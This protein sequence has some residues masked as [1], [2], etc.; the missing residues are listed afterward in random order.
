MD[1]LFGA[2]FNAV[3]FAATGVGV[4]EGGEAPDHFEAAVLAGIDA[5]F[6][7]DAAVGVDQGEPLFV[8][9]IRGRPARA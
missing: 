1:D 2:G 4:G 5:A 7:T 9:Q 8:A 6:A 3:G